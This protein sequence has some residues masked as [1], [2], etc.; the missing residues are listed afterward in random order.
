MERYR[1]KTKVVSQDGILELP[2]D[3][4]IISIKSID[5]YVSALDCIA[6]WEVIYLEPAS[7]NPG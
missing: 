4:L 3:V 1:V 2:D 6:G 5:I 7:D